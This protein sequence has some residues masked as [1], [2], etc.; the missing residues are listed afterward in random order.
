MTM[1]IATILGARPQFIKA[2]ALSRVI[3]KNPQFKEII[4]HTGQHYDSNM[5]DV[6]FE[7]MQIP[8]PDHF[9]QISSKFHGEMTGRMIEAI[10]KVLL[11]DKPDVVLVYGDT[12]STLAGAIAAKK[13]HMKIAH[14]EAGLR[15]FNMAMPEEI[16]RIVAD[17]I[18]DFLFCPGKQAVDNLTKEGFLNFDS[19]VFEVGDIM[20]DVAYFYSP[21]ERQPSFHVP[22]KFVLSTIHRAENTDDPDRLRSILEA[23]N[24][25]SVDLPIVL[26][27]HPRTKGRLSAMDVR[28]SPSV[29][30]VEP[31]GYLEMVYLLKRCSI[32]IT[33][34][35]GLQKE[36]YFF[37]R[38]CITRRDE[39]E[40][41][42]L[43]TEGYNKVV[44][45]DADRI[46]A[47]K[48]DFVS[49]KIAFRKD[50]YGEGKTAE[51]IVEILYESLNGKSI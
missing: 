18:S 23:L 11:T 30:L 38:P 34:S 35:G 50:L 39:T 26:P 15:S 4:I 6:F 22:E 3:R 12:N 13:L 21:L 8:E 25:I 27:L 33:D 40:W 28:L 45:V 20:K 9:L 29:I 41:S 51:K 31:V 36:A 32:V 43:V 5:S 16:N 1:K 48:N 42:E 47:A 44:G 10:E 49:K 14:V 37:D 7:Q 46:I 24:E 2:A 19:G 17:R